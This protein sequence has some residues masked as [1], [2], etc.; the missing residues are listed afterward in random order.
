MG[1]NKNSDRALEEKTEG[2]KPRGRHT[3]RGIDVTKMDLK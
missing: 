1:E 3:H 2:K